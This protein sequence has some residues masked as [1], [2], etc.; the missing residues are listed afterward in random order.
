MTNFPSRRI[1]STAALLTATLI[2]SA[3]IAQQSD[4]ENNLPIRRV[5]MYSSGVAW[6]DH[7]GELESGRGT[8][9]LRFQEDQVADIL[10]SLTVR[11]AGRVQLNMATRIPLHER[12]AQFGVDLSGDTSLPAILRQLRGEEVIAGDVRG[13]ILDVSGPQN[14]PYV[15]EG[16]QLYQQAH[17]L[18][19]VTETG[20]RTVVIEHATTLQLTDEALAGELTQALLTLADARQADVRTVNLNLGEAPNAIAI[21]YLQEAPVWKTSYRLDL[22][23]DD[24]AMFQS[25]AIVENTSD[26]D[27]DNIQLVLASGRPVS[28]VQDLYTPIHLIRPTVTSELQRALGAV[29]YRDGWEEE[30]NDYDNIAAGTRERSRATVAERPEM[31]AADAAAPMVA[32]RAFR[33]NDLALLADATN[34][35][36]AM[37]SGS[38]IGAGF[39]FTVDQPVSLDRGETSMLPIAMGGLEADALSIFTPGGTGGIHPMR[40]ARITNTTDQPLQPG[41][42]TVLDQGAYAGDAQI[43]FI[44]ANA[45]RLIAYAADLDVKILDNQTHASHITTASA[46]EGLLT[47][48]YRTQL[49]RTYSVE[50]EAD[51]SRTLL[52]EHPV[53]HGYE[54]VDDVLQPSETTNSHYRFELAL[55]SGESKDVV[56]EEIRTHNERISLMGL[57]HN[58]ILYYSQLNG[59]PDDVKTALAH[60]GALHQA[61]LDVQTAINEKDGERQRITEEQNRINSNMERLNRNEDL[62]NRYVGIL[63]E[64]ED[65]LIAIEEAYDVL[66]AELETARQALNDYLATMDF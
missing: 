59:I 15:R 5:T 48:R 16:V 2:S 66:R 14:I 17:T 35:T 13:H 44:P 41:P 21:G 60:A 12:L 34:I 43:G 4:D 22:Q 57:N 39:H 29:S 10:K 9:Q 64:Q 7:L 25:W 58:Q 36:Q 20:I 47:I 18:T 24:K 42:M 53:N 33:G 54:L 19:L 45:D 11:G 61:I 38:Q 27:W 37:A 56:I 40:G 49:S 62:Y 26:T 51:D 3:A 52:L 8:I 32:N 28:F 55:E 46:K 63:D 23:G 65:Q 50:S 6:V 30:K 1:L 31:M